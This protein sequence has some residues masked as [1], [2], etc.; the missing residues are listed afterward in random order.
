MFSFSGKMISKS[1]TPTSLI[2]ILLLGIIWLS[3]MGSIT[4]AYFSVASVFAITNWVGL[5]LGLS[6]IFWN[7]KGKLF[8]RVNPLLFLVVGFLL[9]GLTLV[10]DSF[11]GVNR[12]INVLGFQLNI[13]LAFGPMILIA[14]EKLKRPLIS[15]FTV[16]F[17][18]L[19]FLFQPDASQ[20]TAFGG[21]SLMVLHA[22]AKHKSLV[23]LF[24]GLSLAA[25]AYSWIYLDELAP[26]DYVEGILEM[27]YS[28]H[29]LW[30]GLALVSLIFVPLPF[31]LVPRRDLPVLS[32]A[33]GVYFL[34]L[35]VSA[36]FGNFPVL[37][38]GYGI[39]PILGYFSALAWLIEKRNDE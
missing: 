32:Y 3:L 22:Q 20:V 9:L 4:M 8:D 19:I 10:E 6:L 33:I 30:M 36:S 12:W 35:L 17:V 15:F 14:I 24:D 23:L 27:A 29:P 28:L 7:Q 26:V 37:I 34:I 38:M 18:L 11:S 2:L 1:R 13:G 25:S 21:A 5:V 39:S 16:G 31:F